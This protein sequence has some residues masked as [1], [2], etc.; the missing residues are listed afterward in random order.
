M[1]V[2]VCENDVEKTS[3][4]LKHEIGKGNLAMEVSAF[5][6]Y[7][8]KAL[9]DVCRLIFKQFS[10]TVGIAF[11]HLDCDCIKLVGVSPKGEQTSP[12]MRVPGNPPAL[13]EK[14][15]EEAIPECAK[16][17]HD[18]LGIFREK[19]HGMVWNEAKVR[20]SLH[21]K[22]KIRSKVFH[23]DLKKIQLT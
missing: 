4:L 6:E 7:Q 10:N 5:T 14:A 17:S 15:G 11:L 8:K 12:M 19:S 2:K 23:S 1:Q 9:S 22:K 16:C 20:L 3:E 21:A 13:D 18:S